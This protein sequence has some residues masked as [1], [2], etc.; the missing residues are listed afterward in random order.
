MESASVAGNMPLDVAEQID[1]PSSVPRRRRPRKSSV[2]FYLSLVGQYNV[3]VACDLCVDI[4]EATDELT[5][6]DKHDDCLKNRLILLDKTRPNLGYLVRNRPPDYKSSGFRQMCASA[7]ARKRCPEQQLCQ[8]PHTDVERHLWGQDSRGK[9]SIARLVADV[10]EATLSVIYTVHHLRNEYRGTFDLVCRKCYDAGEGR[11]ASLKRRH[12]PRC[13]RNHNMYF[14]QLLL[15][16]PIDAT[17]DYSIELPEEQLNDTLD[18][19]TRSVMDCVASLRANGFS[20]ED[21]ASEARILEQKLRSLSIAFFDRYYSNETAD[22]IDEISVCSNDGGGDYRDL[23]ART[24]DKIFDDHAHDVLDERAFDD[25]TGDCSDGGLVIG[26]HKEPYYRLLPVDE[27][28][29]RRKLYPYVEGKIKLNG[30]FDATCEAIIGDKAEGRS[31]TMSGRLNCGPAFDGDEV[32]IEIDKDDNHRGTVVGVLKRNVHRVARTFVCMV[33]PHEG[34]LMRPLCGTAP[35][36]HIVDTCLRKKYGLESNH[37]VAVYDR[38]LKLKKIIKL[39]AETRKRCLFVVKY[40]K[41][42]VNHKYPLGYV[43]RVLRNSECFEDSQKVLDVLYEVPMKGESTDDGDTDDIDDEKLLPS[44]S[45][46]VHREDLTDWPTLSIDPPNC[47]IVDDALSIQESVRGEFTV[48]VHIADVTHYV[49]KETDIDQESLQRAI[50]FDSG[51]PDHI[52]HMLPPKLAKEKCSLV[53]G[54]RRRCL[55]VKFQFDSDGNLLNKLDS[56]GKQC[57]PEVLQTWI[58]N[59]QQLT[60]EEVQ[61]VI[62]GRKVDSASAHLSAEDAREKTG[63]WSAEKMIQHLHIL[64]QK[65]REERLGDGRHFHRFDGKSLIN[66]DNQCHQARHLVEE[67]MILANST[68]GKL[69][70]KKFPDSTLVVCQEKPR[71]RKRRKWLEDYGW[72]TPYSFF[73]KGLQLPKID[74]IQVDSPIIV[75]R[76]TLEVLET[77]VREKNAIK[78]ENVIGSEEL[79]PIHNLTMLAWNSIQNKA[80]YACLSHA[81]EQLD[82][83]SLNTC[84]YTHFTSPIRRYADI[85]VHR[86]VKA[87]A[88]DDQ[89]CPY[90]NEEIEGSL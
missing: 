57:K 13:R 63:R 29:R 5:L 88:A 1:N 71:K 21:I 28:T 89:P 26:S 48:W 2:K 32:L 74:N 36:F 51:S 3:R 25:D 56:D 4:D 67:F 15:F 50:S 10:H 90:K 84:N 72:I 7:R 76:A 44:A 22:D 69:L 78:F 83:F 55:S 38:G 19:R 75:Q 87:A 49:E 86:L 81:S 65:M 47:R 14:S 77:A 70:A 64:A 42:T 41:W 9:V 80:Q 17:Q 82:H 60:Y 6:R 24:D 68:V 23:V 53:A 73:F 16:R 35:K 27:L 52:C 61:D 31:I 8:F 12:V 20:N 39:D 11:D 43:C 30:S 33:G 85:V 59:Q 66:V 40:L 54:K 62:V 37:F 79:H 46:E 18:E 58:N 45:S 34:N